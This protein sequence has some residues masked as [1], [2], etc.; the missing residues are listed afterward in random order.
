MSELEL[1][2]LRGLS[3][4]LGLVKCVD[5]VTIAGLLADYRMFEDRG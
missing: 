2:D 3:Q 4:L 1:G 5:T